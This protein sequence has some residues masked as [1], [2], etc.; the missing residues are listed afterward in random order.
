AGSTGISVPG[1]PPAN[2]NGGLLTAGR[3]GHYSD[4]VFALVPEVRLGVGYQLTDCARVTLGYNLM[5]W[6]NVARAGDQIDLNVNPRLLPP[7]TAPAVP[8]AIKD[9][10]LW[11]QGVSVGLAFDY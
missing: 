6:T 9:S 5:W 11:I 10:T 3:T 2:I 4:C 7:A 1:S 8:I